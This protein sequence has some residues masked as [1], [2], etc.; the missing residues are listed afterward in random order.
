MNHKNLSKLIENALAIDAEEAKSAGALGFMAR[1]LIQATMPH[2][3]LIIPKRDN[4]KEFV[5]ATEF[6]RKNGAFTLTMLAPSDT[7]LPY[8]AKPRLIMAF[9]SSE[10]VKNRS[11]EIMLGNSLSEFMRKLDLVPT[12]GRWGTIPMLKEQMK[13]LFSTTVSLQ[14]NT[15]ESYASSGFRIANKTVL[16]WDPK[17]PKQAALWKSTV[18]LS[19]EFYDEVI[20]GPIPIDMRALNALKGSSFALDIYCWL[21]YRMSYLKKP[22]TVPWELLAMQFGSEFKYI[23]DFKINFLKHLKKVLTI[24]DA[25]VS[26]EQK[27]LLLKLGY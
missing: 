11:K 12:G 23:R 18:T 17:H 2:K 4:S 6:S 25:K 1:G 8:G 26:S 3:K 10:A 9:I 14:Y 22:I 27:G 24:Y 15:K 19:Q 20:D 21:T 7:G 13:R 16:F 5:N